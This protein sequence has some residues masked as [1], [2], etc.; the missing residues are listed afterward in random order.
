[1]SDETVNQL[2]EPCQKPEVV[3]EPEHDSYISDSW[4]LRTVPKSLKKKLGKLE[5][6][7]AST[8]KWKSTVQI[9]TPI[10]WTR[11]AYR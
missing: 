10:K 8:R 6:L 7:L 4:S 2:P 11:I 5:K 1:M 3:L 9:W